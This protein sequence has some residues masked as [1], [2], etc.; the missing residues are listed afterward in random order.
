MDG[1]NHKV[2]AVEFYP[3]ALTALSFGTIRDSLL[4]RPNFGMV[5][6]GTV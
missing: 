5:F 4:H 3:I 6:N 1:H 2:L